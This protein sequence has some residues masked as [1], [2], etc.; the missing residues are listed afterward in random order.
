MESFARKNVNPIKSAARMFSA[1]LDT[2][3]VGSRQWRRMSRSQSVFTWNIHDVENSE[4]CSVSTARRLRPT[5][6]TVSSSSSIAFACRELFHIPCQSVSVVAVAPAPIT[7]R[8]YSALPKGLYENVAF[9]IFVTYGFASDGQG[10]PP[11]AW[12]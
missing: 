9:N 8:I 10:Y 11:L 7:S 4:C 6:T 12:K 2:R 1:N 5:V 3:Y